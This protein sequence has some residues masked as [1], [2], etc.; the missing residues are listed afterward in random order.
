M[1]CSGLQICLRPVIEYC[2]LALIQKRCNRGGHIIIKSTKR[3]CLVPPFSR[4]TV[5]ISHQ[6]SLINI[7]CRLCFLYGR[8]SFIPCLTVGGSVVKRSSGTSPLESRFF[9]RI[10]RRILLSNQAGGRTVLPVVCASYTIWQKQLQVIEEFFLPPFPGLIDVFCTFKY[11]SPIAIVKQERVV[12]S[13][14]ILLLEAPFG[15]WCTHWRSLCQGKYH[16]GF[17]FIFFK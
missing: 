8:V 6:V 5:P 11:V 10:R 15:R 17:P 4:R 3:F 16:R 2:T 7:K 13:V 14:T 12:H 1:N 9:T